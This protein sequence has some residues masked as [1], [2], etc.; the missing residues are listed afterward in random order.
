MSTAAGAKN[1]KDKSARTLKY[2]EGAARSDG[3]NPFG[4]SGAALLIYQSDW[5]ELSPFFMIALLLKAF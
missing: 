3:A 5:E 1:A 4:P 2:P